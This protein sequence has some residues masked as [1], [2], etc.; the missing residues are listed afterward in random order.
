MSFACGFFK[1]KASDFLLRLMVACAADTLPTIGGI[2]LRRS[3]RV[4]DSIRNTSAPI[5]ESSWV[6][7]G[8]G[9]KVEK[10]S[11]FNPLR[12]RLISTPFL[13]G[14]ALLMSV[15]KALFESEVNK[16]EAVSFAKHPQGLPK[17]LTG[18]TQ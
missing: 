14:G 1:S 13:Y 11:I 9:S 12:G 2:I 3:G 16:E 5:S 4:G 17:K 6:A 15:M 18:F 7:Y 8:P 10:S